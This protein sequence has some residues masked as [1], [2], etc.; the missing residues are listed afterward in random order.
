MEQHKRSHLAPTPTQGFIA[1]DTEGGLHPELSLLALA[2]LPKLPLGTGFGHRIRETGRRLDLG[3]Q[4][5]RITS[6]KPSTNPD[7]S[8]L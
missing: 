5:C 8:W 7:F 3:E 6:Q 1:V 2:H 4:T